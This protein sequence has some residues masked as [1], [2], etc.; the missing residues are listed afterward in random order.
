MQALRFLGY[1]LASPASLFRLP[2]RCWRLF[3]LYLGLAAALVGLA[4]G[5]L[6]AFRADLR[7]A[8]IGFVF[9]ES[10]HLAVEMLID[11]FA[12]QQERIVLI[13]AM[14]A[15]SLLLVS[16]ALFPVKE[17]LS[18]SF[19]RHGSLTEEPVTEHPLWLQ[20]WEEVKLLLMFV[21][22]QASI[23]WIGYHPASWR[24][25]IAIVLSHL[26]I[27]L[28]FSADF[29]SPIFQRR[30][31]RYSRILKTLARQ[32]LAS[33]AFGAL[34]AAPAITVGHMWAR[35]PDWSTGIA[36]TVLF[37]I[38]V[39]SI[40]WAAVAGTW[41]GAKMLPTFAKTRRASLATRVIAWVLVGGLLAANGYAFGAVGR[42]VLHKTQVFKCHYRVDPASFGIRKPSLVGLLADR[43]G[44]G[45]Y[46]DVEIENPTAIDVRLEQNRLEV[47][48][49]GSV[50]ATTRLAPITVPAGERRVQRVD[51]QVGLTPSALRKGRALL[52]ADEW[53]I[54][55]YI[56]VA[57]GFD[58]PIYLLHPGD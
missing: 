27:A 52:Q 39:V 49:G 35:Y 58:F 55:L 2:L 30:R 6:I 57:P 32:P 29:I 37:S 3:F 44:A 16:A 50:V 11:R 5:L 46:F 14:V 4:A 45:V 47:R 34:F 25:L 21:A 17:F 9:P 48:H 56:E 7:S 42:A 53:R 12:D 26:V 1:A 8:L 15:S 23:F 33:L 13:N 54:V 41:L 43:V 20:A 51:L 38:K 10:W 22:V 19:E 18:A 40:A 28:S 31:G 24:Q 36:V